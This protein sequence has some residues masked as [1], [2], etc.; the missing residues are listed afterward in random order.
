MEYNFDDARGYKGITQQEID[1]LLEY[2][3][4][5]VEVAAINEMGKEIKVLRGKRTKEKILGKNSESED[6]KRVI[7]QKIIKELAL[8]LNKELMYNFYL[9]DLLRIVYG[10]R[11]ESK[12]IFTEFNYLWAESRFEKYCLLL[13]LCDVGECVLQIMHKFFSENFNSEKGIIELSENYFKESI[14]SENSN[15][16]TKSI[17]ETL[18]F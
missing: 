12:K 6:V 14:K 11:D 3:S 10:K 18:P 8:E 5:V 2:S 7:I 15:K 13:V 1:F 9:L 16:Q 17:Q 4:Q